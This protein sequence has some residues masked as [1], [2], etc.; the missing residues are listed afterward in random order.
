MARITFYRLFSSA[1]WVLF[2]AGTML[3]TSIIVAG[4]L[5]SGG[6]GGVLTGLY[7]LIAA[8][9]TSAASMGQTDNMVLLIGP[10][11]FEHFFTYLLVPL[12]A[13]LVYEFATPLKK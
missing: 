4:T 7:L 3:V 2:A 11:F 8:L 13:G 1:V 10:H 9:C 12:V 6:A 5:S